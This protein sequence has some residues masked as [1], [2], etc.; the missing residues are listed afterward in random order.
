VEVG[1]VLRIR[2][3]DVARYRVHLGCGCST[4]V[5]PL[6]HLLFRDSFGQN[7]FSSVGLLLSVFR[8]IG[9]L[10]IFRSLRDRVPWFLEF[11]SS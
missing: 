10:S 5:H 7:G 2:P 1:I 11:E 8:V 9:I 6:Y 4:A 3:L